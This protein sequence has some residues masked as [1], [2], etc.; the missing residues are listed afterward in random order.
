[1]AALKRDLPRWLAKA[2][3]QVEP[4]KVLNGDF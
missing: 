2:Y 3:T 4:Y 1:M